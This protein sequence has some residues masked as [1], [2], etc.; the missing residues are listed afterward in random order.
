MLTAETRPNR[1]FLEDTNET[2]FNDED[3]EV[4]YPD[5]KRPLYLATSIN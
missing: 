1:A 2:A 4:K 5:H 3:K